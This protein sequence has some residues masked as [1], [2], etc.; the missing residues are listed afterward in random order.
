MNTLKAAAETK[1]EELKAGFETGKSAVKEIPDLT[2]PGYDIPLGSRH[3]LS[4]VKNKI[5]E[6]F[7]VLVLWWQKDRR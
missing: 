2:A 7:R 3:P 6:I 1:F 5:D 4:L